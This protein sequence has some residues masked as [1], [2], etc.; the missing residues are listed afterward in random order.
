[1]MSRCFEPSRNL[2]QQRRLA[3]PGLAADEDHR[4]GHDSAAEDEIEF[5]ETCLPTSCFRSADIAQAGGRGDAPSITECASTPD[6]A[7]APHPHRRDLRRYNLL[8]EGIPLVARVAA[9]LPFRVLGAALGAAI[10]RLG[11]CH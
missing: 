11:T 10:D 7:R 1:M 6:S 2:E 9:S 8:D 5:V 3:D 4:S